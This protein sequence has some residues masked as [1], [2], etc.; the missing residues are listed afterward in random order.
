M[1]EVSWEAWQRPDGYIC[2][3]ASDG[4]SVT[5]KNDGTTG[6]AF[7]EWYLAEMGKHYSGHLAAMDMILRERLGKAY[8]AI[9]SSEK[10]YRSNLAVAS[11]CCAFGSFDMQPDFSP[12]NG[13]R[14]EFV[15]C[16][17]RCQ[18]RY[19]GFSPSSRGKRVLGCNPVYEL[20]LSE[21]QAQVADMLAHSEASLEEIAVALSLSIQAIKYHATHIYA[22]VGVSGR[23]ALTLKLAGKRLV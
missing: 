7:V 8:A 18:C 23:Q 16:C 4:T 15:P 11:L 6:Y 2:I 14:M 5:V 20:G 22:A 19:N 3:D 10:I 17:C 9:R 1:S 12:E 13:F 21:R